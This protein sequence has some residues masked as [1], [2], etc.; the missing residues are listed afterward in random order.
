[1]RGYF[2]IGVENVS[3]PMNVGNLVRSAHAF[4]AS[5][6]FTVAA[7]FDPTEVDSNTSEAQGQM[8]FYR[9][10]SVAEMRLP[11][12]CT[13]VGIEL[14][15]RAVEL[16]SFRHPRCAAYVLGQERGGLSAG[17]IERCEFLVRIPT[18]FSL[19]LA[20]AGAIV[21]YDRLLAMRRFASRPLMPGAPV[22]PPPTHEW[23]M[24]VW[25]R[26]P[27]GTKTG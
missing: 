24:P 2:A 8:P 12:E 14:D 27:G 3:K 10:A 15:D 20:T 6:A 11:E 26:K 22:E 9:F 5:F 7:A 25:R 17:M 4:G 23:G 1:M 18:Q 13:L 21:M 19:N 16:P